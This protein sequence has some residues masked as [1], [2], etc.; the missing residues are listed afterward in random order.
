MNEPHSSNGWDQWAKKVLADLER[1]D[2]NQSAQN[3][4]LQEIKTELALIKQ[5]Q[6]LKSSLWGAF[7]GIVAALIGFAATL[8]K[9]S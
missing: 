5:E 8:A 6:R 9:R 1:L 2:E 4:V 3:L 7:G